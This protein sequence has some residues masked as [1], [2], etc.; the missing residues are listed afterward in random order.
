MGV[1]HS[2]AWRLLGV[3]FDLPVDIELALLCCRSDR[4]ILLQRQYGWTDTA[5]DW[6]VAIDRSDIDVVDVCLPGDLHHEVAEAALRTGKHVLCEKPLTTCVEDAHNLAN[7]AAIVAEAGVCSMVGYN[8][9]RIP[10]IAEARRRIANGFVGTLRHVRLSYLQ[11]WAISSELGPSWRMDASRAG[12]GVISDLGSHMVD[13][14]MHMTGL[15]LGPVTARATTFVTERKSRGDEATSAVSTDDAF[16]AT[17][18]IEGGG[19][20]SFEASRAAGGHRNDLRIEISGVDGSVVFDL[21]EPEMLRCWRALEPGWR[22][23]RGPDI[24]DPWREGWIGNPNTFATE[25][26][27]EYQA[28]DFIR[29]VLSGAPAV[30]DFADGAQ[31]FAILDRVR[32]A[33]GESGTLIPTSSPARRD[34]ER[35]T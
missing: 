28:L 4:R 19:I 35:I 15:R 32:A 24:N 20:A 29:A 17:F 6:R 7:V 30:P 22:T 9:R 11:D 33:S 31:V 10:A 14:A 12:L 13:L 27:Y 3:D 25:I 1:A 2:R 18:D 21:R 5:P 34:E 16:L 8:Y 23:I 26:T